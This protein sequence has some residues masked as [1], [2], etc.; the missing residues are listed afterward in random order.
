MHSKQNLTT[1]QYNFCFTQPSMYTQDV[2]KLLLKLSNHVP[3]Q[4]YQVTQLCNQC[5]PYSVTERKEEEAVKTPATILLRN[6]PVGKPG[7]TNPT[8]MQVFQYA[9]HDEIFIPETYDSSVLLPYLKIK[10]P[11]TSILSYVPFTPATI[12]LIQTTHHAPA[13]YKASLSRKRITLTIEALVQT[14]P[15]ASL[16][17]TWALNQ[18]SASQATINNID[19]VP[20]V[21]SD[22]QLWDLEHTYTGPVSYTHLTLPTIYSV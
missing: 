10:Y 20:E 18:P 21:E 6:L 4:T 5:Q 22:F 3:I 7:T 8:Q 15:T 1:T 16:Y 13:T 9:Y 2:F 12:K 11:H 19:L 14:H 17:H